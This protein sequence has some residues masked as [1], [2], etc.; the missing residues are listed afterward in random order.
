MCLMKQL[1]LRV[2]LLRHYV[3]HTAQHTSAHL[4]LRLKT[5]SLFGRTTTMIPRPERETRE[6]IAVSWV[7]QR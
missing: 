4:D 1:I 6:A 2:P 5:S 3:M 7:K